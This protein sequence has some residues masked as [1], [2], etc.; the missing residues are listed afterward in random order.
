MSQGTLQLLSYE[1]NKIEFNLNKDYVFNKA[2]KIEL[3]QNLEKNIERIDE[4]TF[5]VSL[6][7]EI[8]NLEEKPTP[9]TLS[10]KISGIFHLNNWENEDNI[11]LATVNTI[12]ILFP[13]VRS[14]VATVTAN[15]SVPPYI[16]PIF[17]VAAWL[18]QNEK[19]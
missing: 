14:L 18:E 8:F 4:N 9:F 16:L 11:T 6:S 10:I 17:N 2:K 13:F 19:K 7:F 12:A 5:K 15:T 1:V 3:N